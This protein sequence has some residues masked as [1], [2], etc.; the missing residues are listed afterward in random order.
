MV[1][2]KETKSKWTDWGYKLENNTHFIFYSS[3]KITKLAL[4]KIL[5]CQ[6][7]MQRY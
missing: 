1:A 5:I 6:F 3:G 4:A 2:Q 7:V